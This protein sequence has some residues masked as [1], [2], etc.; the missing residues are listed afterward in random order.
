MRLFPKRD[1]EDAGITLIG[2]WIFGGVTAVALLLFFYGGAFPPGNESL[3]DIIRWIAALAA[4]I[5]AYLT[6]QVIFELFVHLTIGMERF[7]FVMILAIIG[8]LI[9]Q[10]AML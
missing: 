1:P 5:G 3:W 6:L 7:I 4:V 9:Y 10:T 8:F 2:L